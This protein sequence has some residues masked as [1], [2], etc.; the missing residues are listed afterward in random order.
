MSVVLYVS[1]TSLLIVYPAIAK[2][3][4]RWIFGNVRKNKTEIAFQISTEEMMMRSLRF[5]R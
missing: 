3:T 1:D 2:H 5:T 4:L